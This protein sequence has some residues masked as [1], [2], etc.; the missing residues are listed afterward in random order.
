M[1]KANQALAAALRGI[2]HVRDNTKAPGETS[3]SQANQEGGSENR[4]GNPG[5][6]ADE[7]ELVP[8]KRPRASLVQVEKFRNMLSDCEVDE[9]GLAGDGSKK[10][11]FEPHQPAPLSPEERNFIGFF[12]DLPNKREWEEMGQRSAISLFGDMMGVYE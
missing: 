5:L 12:A 3:G 2:G 6:E 10:A 11:N 1:S 8:R 9:G 7:S 4:V